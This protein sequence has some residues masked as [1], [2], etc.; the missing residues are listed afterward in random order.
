MTHAKDMKV[1]RSHRP[2]NYLL[3]SLMSHLF[4]GEWISFDHFHKDRDGGNISLLSITSPNGWNVKHW[5]E[6][7]SMTLKKVLEESSL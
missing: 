2:T 3:L 1:S 4:T 7:E 5:Q 6:S